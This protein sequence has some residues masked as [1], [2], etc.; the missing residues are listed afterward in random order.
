M[1]RTHND[2]G[3][4]LE[5]Y[6]QRLLEQY[7]NAKHMRLECG[8]TDITTSEFHVEIKKWGSYKQ[9]Y[10]QL[11]VYQAQCWRPKLYAVFF[12]TTTQK[13]KDLA[14]SIFKSKGIGVY[15]IDNR[16]EIIIYCEPIDFMQVDD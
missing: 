3:E 14:I 15:E 8:I 2:K 4:K 7:L 6:Y 5:L 12:G 10:G 11:E 1:S 16:D 9:V 13:N